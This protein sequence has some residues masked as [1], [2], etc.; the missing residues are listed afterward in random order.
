MQ[1]A[2]TFP[3]QHAPFLIQDCQP[4]TE[5]AVLLPM[6]LQPGNSERPR[7]SVPVE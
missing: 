6:M 5:L 4:G 7:V 3:R 2:L 1:A